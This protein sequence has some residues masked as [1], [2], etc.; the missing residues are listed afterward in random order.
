M[1]TLYGKVGRDDIMSGP[2]ENGVVIFL[3]SGNHIAYHDFPASLDIPGDP[4]ELL[5]KG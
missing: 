1:D 3:R 2:D 5:W 4:A